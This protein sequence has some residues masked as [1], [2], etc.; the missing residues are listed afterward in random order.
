MG[1]V[2]ALAKLAIQISAPFVARTCHN[3][4]FNVFIWINRPARGDGRCSWLIIHLH[5]C[6][7]AVGPSFRRHVGRLVRQGDDLVL[8][9][10]AGGHSLPRNLCRPRGWECSSTNPALRK[11]QLQ[12]RADQQRCCQWWK[13]VRHLER[14]HPECQR[15]RSRHNGGWPVSGRRE[16]RGVFSG[17]RS[18]HKGKFPIGY[19]PLIRERVQGCK[20]HADADLIQIRVIQIGT[21]ASR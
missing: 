6:A 12:D 3:A 11:R 8:E 14:I 15:R 7:G 9:R 5:R 19:D 4:R 17:S 10:R 1:T 18:N 13:I 2:L 21:A 20:H 16:R